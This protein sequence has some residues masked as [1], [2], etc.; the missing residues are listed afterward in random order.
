MNLEELIFGKKVVLL[1]FYATWCGPCM[2]MMPVLD[3]LKIDFGDN[4][5]IIKIDV[6][7]NLDFAVDQKVMGVP[8][9]ILLVDGKEVWREA[10]TFTATFLSTVI[11]KFQQ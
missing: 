3:R 1:D 9:F 5:H 7:K 10:G 8:M 4:L 6:D 11:G 2:A